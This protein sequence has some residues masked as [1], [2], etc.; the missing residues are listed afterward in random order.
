MSSLRF[1]ADSRSSLAHVWTNV[2]GTLRGRSWNRDAG[3]ATSE[4][5]EKNFVGLRK[6]A[7]NGLSGKVIERCARP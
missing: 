3:A 2:S 4:H 6:V 1:P 5:L 7:P